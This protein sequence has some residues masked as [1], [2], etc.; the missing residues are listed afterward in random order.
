MG[1][2]ICKP[3]SEKN[4]EKLAGR[5]Y[6]SNCGFQFCSVASVPVYQRL[7]QISKALNQSDLL[8]F[9]R[10]STLLAPT[11]YHRVSS[12]KKTPINHFR[13]AEGHSIGLQWSTAWS[14]NRRCRRR[15]DSVQELRDAAARS[16]L[17]VRLP[18]K[19]SARRLHRTTIIRTLDTRRKMCA[20][21]LR[22]LTLFLTLA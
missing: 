8:A 13:P 4:P 3:S 7:K 22:L 16:D 20:F 18:W 14:D 6:S 12:L 11:Q 15:R 9:N 17:I 5:L 21:V 1:V 2:E 10:D 19:R